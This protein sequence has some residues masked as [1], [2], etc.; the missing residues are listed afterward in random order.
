M[1]YVIIGLVYL[2]GMVLSFKLMR[3]MVRRIWVNK[4]TWENINVSLFISLGSW[5]FFLPILLIIIG[6]WIGK[7]INKRWPDPPKWL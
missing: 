7:R 3:Y 1:I 5:F 4:W 6:S 2:V